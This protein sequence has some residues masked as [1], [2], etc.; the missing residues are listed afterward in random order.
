MYIP[1]L[2]CMTGNW[3]LSGLKIE[4]IFEWI[5]S[6][7]DSLTL[8]I[9]SQEYYIPSFH[10][11]QLKIYL[12][13]NCPPKPGIALKKK[14]KTKS[15]RRAN[16]LICKCWYS[17]EDINNQD[18]LGELE[19]VGAGGRT[20]RGERGRGEKAGR[21][22]TRSSRR[23]THCVVSHTPFCS[24]EDHLAMPSCY[25]CVCFAVKV[26]YLGVYNFSV[27]HPFLIS[28]DLIFVGLFFVCF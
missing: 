21:E 28:T 20:V 17:L 5:F 14:M 18:C 9:V 1:L 22:P 23:E 12:Y 27:Y 24:T 13:L 8:E 19:E 7:S 11:R 10:R 26:S 3:L 6:L 4:K 25:L 15:K 16:H 2:F